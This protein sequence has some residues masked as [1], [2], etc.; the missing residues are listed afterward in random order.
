MP[1]KFKLDEIVMYKDI[2]WIVKEIIPTNKG[3]E[4]WLEYPQ[5]SGAGIYAYEHE[6]S[7]EIDMNM[8]TECECGAKH[9]S[10]PDFH[11]K[12]CPLGGLK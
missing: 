10:F 11:A 8:S 5:A 3:T 2:E 9:T 12:W 4:Y 1:F 6:I 7:E